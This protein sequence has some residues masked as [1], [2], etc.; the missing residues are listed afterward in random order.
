M[1]PEQRKELWR[2]AVHNR[3]FELGQTIA[4]I[5]STFTMLAGEK[6]VHDKAALIGRQL[7]VLELEVENLKQMVSNFDPP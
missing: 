1:T 7:R 4:E 6:I 5:R 3:S 2:W